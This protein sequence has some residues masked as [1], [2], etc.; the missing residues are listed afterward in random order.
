MIVQPETVVRWH[1][2]GF[3]LYWRSISRPGPGR[4]RV[5]SAVRELSNRMATGRMIGVVSLTITPGIPAGRIPRTD[6]SVQDLGI[7]F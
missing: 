1:R 3:R 4:S 6:S 5:S 7:T 2:K